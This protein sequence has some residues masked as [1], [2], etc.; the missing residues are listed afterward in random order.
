MSKLTATLCLTIAVLLEVTRVSASPDIEK[1]LT[2]AQSGDFATPLRGWTPLAK[3]GYT[4]AQYNLRLMYDDG[5]S[6]PKN[7]KTAVKC[8]RLAAEP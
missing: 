6:V 4:D 7:D 2:A 5:Q 3:K 1:G 8:Y